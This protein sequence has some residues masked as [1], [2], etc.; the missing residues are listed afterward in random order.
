MESLIFFLIV[1]WG[2]F[3]I[4]RAGSHL[5][6]DLKTYNKKFPRKSQAKTITGWLR[7]KT[8]FDW[9]H[10]HLGIILIFISFFLLN[11]NYNLFLVIF[12]IGISLFADQIFPLLN[13]GNYFGRKMFS[14]SIIL[15]LVISLIGFILI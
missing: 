8:G 4:T 12:A 14:V 2:T 6:H 13:F 1:L 11:F 7:I 5:F 9:H 3:F 15:H 10:I